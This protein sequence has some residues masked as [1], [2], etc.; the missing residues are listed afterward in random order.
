[1]IGR[2]RVIA[3]DR[4]VPSGDAFAELNSWRASNNV[5]NA[6]Q[7]SPTASAY[8]AEATGV[9]VPVVGGLG[10]DALGCRGADRGADGVVDRVVRGLVDRV[11]VVL[12]FVV[13]CETAPALDREADVRAV[14]V[15]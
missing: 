12:V 7:S 2:R 10:G 9:R 14:D 11:D 3:A 6:K 4:R 15:R 1:M 5:H 8:P 13:R